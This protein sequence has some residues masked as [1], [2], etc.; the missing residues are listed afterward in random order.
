M[1]KLKINIEGYF[2]NSSKIFYTF[3]ATDLKFEYKGALNLD[4]YDKWCVTN[5]NLW[6]MDFLIFYDSTPLNSQF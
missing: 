6:T 3:W 5:Q 1:K 4:V 2:K